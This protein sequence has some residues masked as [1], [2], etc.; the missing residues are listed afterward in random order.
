MT[1]ILEEYVFQNGD[2]VLVTAKRERTHSVYLTEEEEPQTKEEKMV[3]VSKHIVR[4]VA[5]KYVRLTLER[6]DNTKVLFDG[7]C[8]TCDDGKGYYP[9]FEQN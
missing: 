9:N 7:F 6:E 4:V 1:T 8:Y 5:R 2:T 3:E